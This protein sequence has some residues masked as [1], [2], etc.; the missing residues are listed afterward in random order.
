MEI[1]N[2]FNHVTLKLIWFIL[3][4]EN[5]VM[6][7]SV[8]P[9]LTLF[10]QV[11]LSLLVSL[12]HLLPY[13]NKISEG[14]T[15]GPLLRPYIPK[16]YKNDKA[17]YQLSCDKH[18]S[19]VFFLFCQG[20]EESGGLGKVNWIVLHINTYVF[21][22]CATREIA[23]GLFYVPAVWGIVFCCCFL[24]FSSPVCELL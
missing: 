4:W 17:K 23:S 22:S 24:S 16:G 5:W 6:S 15:S 19:F 21:V 9:A 7:S 12:A 2:Y 20:R 8:N 14:S 13:P 11:I 18:H 10:W 3:M 1:S